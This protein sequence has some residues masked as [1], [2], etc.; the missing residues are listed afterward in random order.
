M[1]DTWV[2]EKCLNFSQKA[3]INNVMMF[4]CICHN[5]TYPHCFCVYNTDL[6]RC[7]DACFWSQT[8]QAQ[9]KPHLNISNPDERSLVTWCARQ[10]RSRSWRFRNLLTTSAPKVKDTPRSFS[11]QP[12]TSL[13]GSDH[14]RSHSSP[15]THTKLIT[16][17]SL[18]NTISEV[19]GVDFL[20][21]YLA[22]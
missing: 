21:S 14:S 15:G 2:I 17:Q 7:T 6:S 20:F 11:P 12:W 16:Y 22:A 4:N 5:I 10:M 13:S 18:L 3:E 9:T 8:S 1:W 19:I